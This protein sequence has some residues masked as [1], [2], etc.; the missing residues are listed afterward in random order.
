MFLE[1]VDVPSWAALLENPQWRQRLYQQRQMGDAIAAVT[2]TIQLQFRAH[3]EEQ[4]QIE[5]SGE[6]QTLMEGFE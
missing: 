3:R 2:E 4:F 1:W 5:I 6:G